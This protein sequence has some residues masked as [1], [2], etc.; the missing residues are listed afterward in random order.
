VEYLGEYDM[1][2]SPAYYWLWNV[3]KPWV[4]KM[5]KA[6]GRAKARPEVADV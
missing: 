4:S 3:A 5:L 1:V 6:R 2:I